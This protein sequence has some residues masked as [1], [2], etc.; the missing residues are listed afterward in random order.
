MIVCAHCRQRITLIRIQS[1]SPNYKWV[2]DTRKPS[3]TWKCDPTPE[4]PVRAHA[5]A[6]AA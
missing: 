5:P 1:D 2:T 3:D 6:E 4:F